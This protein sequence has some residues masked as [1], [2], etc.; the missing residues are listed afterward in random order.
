LQIGFGHTGS[1]S[2][3]V[4]ASFQSSSPTERRRASIS[5]K[6]S[7]ELPSCVGKSR[8]CAGTIIYPQEHGRRDRA[9]ALP[10]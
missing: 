1:I 2:G 7:S 3:L 9:A 10:F 4:R 6:V 8:S 5:E